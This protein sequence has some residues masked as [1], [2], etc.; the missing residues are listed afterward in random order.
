MFH[1][2][3]LPSAAEQQT[4]DADRLEAHM[5]AAILFYNSR[6]RDIR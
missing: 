5:R 3:H 1:T 4:G 2:Q 6:N